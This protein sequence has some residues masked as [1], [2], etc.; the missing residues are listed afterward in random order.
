MYLGYY[1]VVIEI[2]NLFF[3]QPMEN[4]VGELLFGYFAI[5]E[6]AALVFM[7][8]R[9]FLNYFPVINTL[10]VFFFMLYCKFAH[11]G[12]K[13]LAVLGMQF[14]GIALFSWMVLKL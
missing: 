5:I 14:L 13:I 6:F 10:F 7:R 9:P 8:T 2:S 11:V 3:E 1:T 4:G 12:F